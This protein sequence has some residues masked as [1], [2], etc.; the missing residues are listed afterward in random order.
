MKYL[1][2][3]LLLSIISLFIVS[4]NSPE[5]SVGMTNWT[6]DGTEFKFYLGTE[7][8]IDVVKKW[9]ELQNNSDWEGSLELFVDTAT[10]TYQNGQKV[11]ATEMTEMARKRDSNYK[12]NNI[13]YSWFHFYKGFVPQPN[14]QTSKN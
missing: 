4:C 2:Q 13:D 5:R 8:A 7:Q 3:L 10:V 12:A 11:A 6:D 14:R 9:D 1:K